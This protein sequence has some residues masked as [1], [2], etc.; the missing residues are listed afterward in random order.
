VIRYLDKLVEILLVIALAATA[1][2]VSVAVY[3][4]YVLDDSLS[5]SEEITSKTLV[6]I[7]FLGSYGCFR[8]GQHLTVDLI[9]AW[10]GRRGKMLLEAATSLIMIAFCLV[11]TWYS[12]RVTSTVGKAYINTLD[13][14][15]AYFLAALPVSFA[16]MALALLYRL[17][18]AA[19]LS[20]AEETERSVV[21]EAVE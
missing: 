11:M 4:R 13:I 17:F 21:R 2:I 6:W 14:P 1:I 9:P 18:G 16:L 10:I 7:T 5:W 15:R 19:P 8:R 12:F 20:T 3:Y